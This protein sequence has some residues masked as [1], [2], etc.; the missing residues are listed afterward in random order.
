[1][2]TGGQTRSFTIDEYGRLIDDYGFLVAR[3]GTGQVILD[4]EGKPH[5]SSGRTGL[6]NSV[7]S[8]STLPMTMRTILSMWIRKAS[9]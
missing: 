4:S 6:R 7:A 8:R 1:M 5:A 2:T 3:D 9:G